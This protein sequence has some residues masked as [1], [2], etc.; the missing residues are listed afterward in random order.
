MELNEKMMVEAIA[1][2]VCERTG[3]ALA[4]AITTRLDVLEKRVERLQAELV[5]VARL[6]SQ[7][8]C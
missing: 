2:R 7:S 3:D 8:R 5:E 6:E 4:K 1:Y